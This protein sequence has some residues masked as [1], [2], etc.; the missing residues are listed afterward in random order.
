M[1]SGNP[2][3]IFYAST[4]HISDEIREFSQGGCHCI[5]RVPGLFG[6]HVHHIGAAHA[7]QPGIIR[8]VLISGQDHAPT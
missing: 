7:A 5:L 2:E 8:T 6:E 4:L 1:T 3:V